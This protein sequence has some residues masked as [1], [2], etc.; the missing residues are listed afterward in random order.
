MATEDARDDG[1]AGPLVR[2]AAGVLFPISASTGAKHGNADALSRRPCRRPGC[3]LPA[4]DTE[5]IGTATLNAFEA[6]VLLAG[7]EGAVRTVEIDA[8][9]RRKLATS[10]VE[11]GRLNA[12]AEP[13][14]PPDA[15][16]AFGQNGWPN[17]CT[18]EV[19]E[20]QRR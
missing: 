7:K 11:K 4:E 13:W 5:E 6:D 16:R 8:V 19:A 12:M 20:Q 10:S 15:E 17:S 3:C 14:L 18:L 2:T 1:A 9:R